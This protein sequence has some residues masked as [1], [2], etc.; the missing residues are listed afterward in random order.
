MTPP[1]A[2]LRAEQ[3]ASTMDIHRATRLTKSTVRAL[4]F[5]A[6]AYFSGIIVINSIGYFTTLD[7][8]PFLLEKAALGQDAFWRACLVVHVGGGL[9][10]L[11]AAL[12]Q[13]SRVLLRRMP[14]VHQALGWTYVATVLAVVV[15]PG[16]YLA[17]YA[18]G[19][20]G[21]KLGFVLTGVLLFH[22]TWRGLERV[23]AHDFKGHVAWMLRSY[24][25]AASA[26]TF[27]LIYLGLFWAGFGTQYVAAIWLSLLVNVLAVEAFLLWKRKGTPA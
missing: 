7:D 18:K 20:L 26:I 14:R 24:G 9:L 2:V 1:T 27:R 23:L 22:A 21:G 19:G 13:F 17:L 25:L 12:P 16:L 4:W 3:P 5:S 10:C 11:I 15:P 8:M 6:L